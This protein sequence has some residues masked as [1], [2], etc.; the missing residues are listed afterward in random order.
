MKKLLLTAST[1]VAL[2][3]PA[4]AITPKQAENALALAAV[5][6]VHYS[7]CGGQVSPDQWSM[8]TP[9]LQHPLAKLLE[10]KAKQERTSCAYFR[11]NYPATEELARRATAS[12]EA[13]KQEAP[14]YDLRPDPNYTSTKGFPIYNVN[15]AALLA[16]YVVTCGGKPTAAATRDALRIAEEM[17]FKKWLEH[18]SWV[19]LV[20]D[21]EQEQQFCENALKVL[22]PAIST[23]Q[24]DIDRPIP[25][26]LA[27]IGKLSRRLAYGYCELKMGALFATVNK[28]SCQ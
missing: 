19:H 25:E 15:G 6:T 13:R 16:E 23:Q 9:Y 5:M 2:A 28:E 7:K 21:K 4:L 11:V 22:G 20:R 3:T 10:Q 24:S 14:R 1:L 12:Q 8:V 27:V 18:V 17:G 26:D